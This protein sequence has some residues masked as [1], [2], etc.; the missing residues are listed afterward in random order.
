MAISFAVNGSDISV[1]KRN[2]H[3]IN[4]TT[5]YLE[6]NGLNIP[7]YR[8]KLKLLKII[9]MIPTGCVDCAPEEPLTLLRI[10]NMNPARLITT[11]SPFFHVM[12]SLMAT[13]AINIV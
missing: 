12:G 2:I 13:A 11:P 10:R 5:E 3:F 6:I 9:S 7:R 4:V 8:E 1:V